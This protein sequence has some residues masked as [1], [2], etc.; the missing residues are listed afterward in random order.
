MN[1][2]A[3]T[4]EDLA[5]AYRMWSDWYDEQPVPLLTKEEVLDL[6]TSVFGEII[7]DSSRGLCMI[8]PDACI[9]MAKN[10]GGGTLVDYGAY[11][12]PK[13]RDQKLGSELLEMAL[14]SAS[15]MGYRRVVAAPYCENQGSQRWLARAGFVPVQV[16]MAK[17]I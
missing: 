4:A 1:I 13:L 15:E 11:V 2:R 9:V 17:E 14:R 16:L 5:S 8:A 12:V 10:N 3:S 7:V 6:Q